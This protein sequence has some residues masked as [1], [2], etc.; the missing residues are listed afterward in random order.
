VLCW[1]QPAGL[2]ALKVLEEP[3]ASFEVSVLSPLGEAR[4]LAL[5]ETLDLLRASPGL[6]G[7]QEPETK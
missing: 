3:L 5:I 4:L 6:A 7:N 1:I 2:T